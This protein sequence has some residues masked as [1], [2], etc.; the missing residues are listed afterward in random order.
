MEFLGHG[1]IGH[2]LFLSF[3]LFLEVSAASR[4]AVTLLF[5][6]QFNRKSYQIGIKE[7]GI[8]AMAVRKVK[9]DVCRHSFVIANKWG[10]RCNN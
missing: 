6:I 8:W 10:P 1:L 2:L 4:M 9:G 3:Y 7:F 5:S